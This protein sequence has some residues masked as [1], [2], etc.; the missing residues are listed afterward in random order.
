[1]FARRQRLSC[2]R[3]RLII[4]QI[5]RLHMHD[6]SAIET[7]PEASDVTKLLYSLLHYKV[8]LKFLVK[9]VVNA[10]NALGRNVVQWRTWR[11]AK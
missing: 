5:D 3:P 11:L 1:M 8:K 2:Q 7:R 6:R 4:I 9:F 10:V